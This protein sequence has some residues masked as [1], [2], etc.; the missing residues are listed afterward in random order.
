MPHHAHHLLTPRAACPPPPAYYPPPT[1][2][3]S[4][5]PCCG[6]RILVSADWIWVYLTDLVAWAS[7]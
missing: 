3:A 2:S 5:R 7:V 6:A 1:L 4:T